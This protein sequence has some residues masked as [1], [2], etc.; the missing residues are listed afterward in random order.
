MPSHQC[1]IYFQVQEKREGLLGAVGRRRRTW[2][3]DIRRVVARYC[4]EI[5]T[6]AWGGGSSIERG[7]QTTQLVYMCSGMPSHQCG[8]YFQVQ[9]KREVLF[10]AVGRRHRTLE[11]DIRRLVAGYCREILTEAWGGGSSIEQGTQT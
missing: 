6:E 2:E 8:I 11:N 4:R 1:G 7:T 9:E 3:N 5:R 10:G